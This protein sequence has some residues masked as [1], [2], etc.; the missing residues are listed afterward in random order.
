[1]TRGFAEDHQAIRA[2]KGIDAELAVL[3]VLTCRGVKPMSR[4]EKLLA[5]PD[6]DHLRRLGL[7][8]RPIERTVQSGSAIVETIF[9][10]SSSLL[11]LYER[12]FGTRPVDKSAETVRLEG[13]L[14]GYPPC[15]VEQYIR[16]PYAANDLPQETQKL[17]FHWACPQCAVTPLLVPAY[18]AALDAVE[19]V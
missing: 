17:L 3:A 10:A 11:D 9:A 16:R 1:M 7:L 6:L 18:R 5:E 14:F 2:I 13:F 4:W 15:C 8:A 19:K 12:R